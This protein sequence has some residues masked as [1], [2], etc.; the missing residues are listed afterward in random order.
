MQK[1]KKIN[2]KRKGAEG[3]REFANELRKHGFEGARR[4]G[5]YAGSPDSPDVVGVEGIHFEVKRTE[6]TDIYGWMGQAQRDCGENIP[7]VGFRKNGEKWV[8]I[9]T[10]DDFCERFLKN[11]GFLGG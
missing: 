8:V 3:E 1:H 7:V 11:D 9:L 10:L 4:G 5:Q 6:R 2:S